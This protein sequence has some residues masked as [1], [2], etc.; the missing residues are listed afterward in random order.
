MAFAF[1]GQ[2]IRGKPT[3]KTHDKNNRRNRPRNL[4]KMWRDW[5]TESDALFF[6]KIR[7]VHMPRLLGGGG[8]F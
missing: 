5:T 7:S 1:C 4:L 8:G 6:K 3:P 2:K